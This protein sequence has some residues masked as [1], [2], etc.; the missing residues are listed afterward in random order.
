M[1]LALGAAFAA[2]GAAEVPAAAEPARPAALSWVRAPGAELCASGPALAEEVERVLGGAALVPASQ[3]EIT[4]EGRVARAGGSF[5]TSLTLVSRAGAVLGTR[6][7]TTAGPGCGALTAEVALVVALMIDP[8]AALRSRASSGGSAA[9]SA[10][11]AAPP[12]APSG[13]SAAPSTPPS[14]ASSPAPSSASSPALPGASAGGSA[15]TS[16]PVAVPRAAPCPPPAPPSAPAPP[17]AP[18]RFDVSLGPVLA[19]GLVPPVGG[20]LRV[21]AA[22]APPRLFF[23]EVGADVL[24]PVRV[25]QGG[26]GV[27]L[28]LAQGRVRACPLEIARGPWG[29]SACAGVDLGSLRGGG[30]GFPISRSQELLVAAAALSGRV[31]LHLG[32][33]AHVSLGADLSV[34][35]QR[36]RF[37]YEAPDG[38][39]REIFVTSPLSGSADLSVGLAL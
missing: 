21:R 30:F 32:R 6:R 25:E 3:A 9:P 4:V 26:Q 36:G 22:V 35:F 10:G 19:A 34:P 14:S 27:E 18:W 39:E 7:I 11:S 28:F 8:D 38:A 1:T 12:A 33:V 2:L 5:E 23:F 37:F 20:G 13:G 29:A 16:G 31:R 15:G 24:A 17:P